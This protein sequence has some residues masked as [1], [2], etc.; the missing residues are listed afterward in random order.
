MGTLPHRG[1]EIYAG[2]PGES[3]VKTGVRCQACAECLGLA[4]ELR[5]QMAGHRDHHR[6]WLS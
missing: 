1:R 2:G 4:A 6:R 5:L 3:S